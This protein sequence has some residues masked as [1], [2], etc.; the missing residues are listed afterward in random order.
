[1]PIYIS[2]ILAIVILL[3]QLEIFEFV[4]TLKKSG[5]ALQIIALHQAL[6]IN[7]IIEIVTNQKNL[8]LSKSREGLYLPY[9]EQEIAHSFFV[10]GFP[11]ILIEV[12][13]VGL[14]FKRSVLIIAAAC[15]LYAF[16]FYLY[17][18]FEKKKKE[19]LVRFAA[20]FTI[21]IISSYF[22]Y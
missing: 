11:M 16:I 15:F 18:R 4:K 1:M 20:Y 2:F 13:I 10:L 8:L 3:Y 12:L 7:N 14:I 22:L 19:D 9:S 5:F 17:L 21:F 6:V